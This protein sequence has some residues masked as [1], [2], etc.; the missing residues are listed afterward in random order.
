MP[1]LLPIPEATAATTDSH[2]ALGSPYADSEVQSAFPMSET[3]AASC[4]L[5]TIAHSMI[6]AYYGCTKGTLAQRASAEIAE[7]IY[8]RLLTWASSLT[9]NMVQRDDSDHAVLLMQ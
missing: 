3:F 2:E 4:R 8:S 6:V 9:M 5:W 1:P 7:A